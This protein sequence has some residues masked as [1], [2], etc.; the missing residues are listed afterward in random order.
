MDLPVLA[1]FGLAGVVKTGLLSARDVMERSR[2]LNTRR[3]GFEWQQGCAG[4]RQAE[5]SLAAVECCACVSG[6]RVCGLHVDSADGG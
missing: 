6:G 2:Q 3:F 1:V 5:T 4:F